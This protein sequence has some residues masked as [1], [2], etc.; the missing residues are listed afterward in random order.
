[1][2]NLAY[3]QMSIEI[4]LAKILTSSVIIK[5]IFLIVIFILSFNFINAK[6]CE[7]W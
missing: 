5:C 3:I 7:L 1:M 4:F 6:L 2:Q